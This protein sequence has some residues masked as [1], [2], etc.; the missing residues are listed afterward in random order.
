MIWDEPKAEAF[1]EAK[2]YKYTYKCKPCEVTWCGPISI[3][4][5]WVCRKRYSVKISLPPK[6]K[7]K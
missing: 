5:C 7:F 6:E 3:S 2:K 4:Q 1:M